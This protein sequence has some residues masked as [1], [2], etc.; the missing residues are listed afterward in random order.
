MV[1][2]HMPFQNGA[3]PLPGQLTQH[4]TK[5]APDFAIQL[6]FRT[7]KAVIK[8]IFSDGILAAKRS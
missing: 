6:T 4:R 3:P 5:K 1:L 7:P 8:R 2:H